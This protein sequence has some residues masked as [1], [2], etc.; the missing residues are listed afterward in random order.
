MPAPGGSP[1]EILATR[2]SGI[3]NSPSVT[4]RPRGHQDGVTG[5]AVAAEL[6]DI[7]KGRTA[8]VAYTVPSASAA[9]LA[10]S[11]NVEPGHGGRLR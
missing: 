8:G 10:R 11:G 6:D 1:A 9:L 4:P 5:H 3:R 7:A 2:L